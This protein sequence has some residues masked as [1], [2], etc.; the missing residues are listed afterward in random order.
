MNKRQIRILISVACFA[1]IIGIGVGFLYAS[2]THPRLDKEILERQL[3]E[4][5]EQEADKLVR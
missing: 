2:Q 3:N 1:L 5:L 4:E